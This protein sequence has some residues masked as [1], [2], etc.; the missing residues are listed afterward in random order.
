MKKFSNNLRF[1]LTLKF[2]EDNFISFL[3]ISK[4]ELDRQRAKGLSHNPTKIS[5]LESQIRQ[6]EQQLNE[7]KH[8]FESIE[9]RK[10]IFFR[11]RFNSQKKTSSIVRVDIS[12][13]YS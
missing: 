8:R 10:I 9:V 13:S 6:Y 5:Q 7:I 12:L 4:K 3:K 2:S 11:K 1:E